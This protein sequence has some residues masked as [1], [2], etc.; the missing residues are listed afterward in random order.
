[1][2]DIKKIWATLKKTHM[3]KLIYYPNFEPRDIDWLKYA[4]IYVDQFSPIIPKSGKGTLSSDFTRIENETDLVKILE[5][6]WSQGDNAATK[7]LKEIEY[8][9]SHPDQFMDILGVVNINRTWKDPKNWLFELYEEK[10]NSTFKSECL[11]KGLGVE[12]Q[13]GILTSK[14]LAQLYMTFLAEEIAFDNVANPITDSKKYDQLSNYLRAKSPQKENLLNSAKTTV[15][16]S[17][18]KD[19]RHVDLKKFIEFRKDS[20]IKELRNSF[21]QSLSKFYESIED[22]FNPR[23]YVT[24]IQSSN[25]EL[26]KEIGLF[27]GGAISTTL[28]GMILISN[29]N[30]LEATKQ[31][32]EGTILTILGVTAIN[33]SWA[34]GREKRHARKFLSK[35][36]QI[37]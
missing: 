36:N 32:I 23:E 26:T 14:E 34:D 20:G 6:K 9:E 18:P 37:E 35:I 13:R 31:I 17:L 11:R 24:N 3:D 27:F 8:I 15:N 30:N 21:N 4:L 7:A 33:K 28:G 2:R 5:P 25:S 10:F 12:S 1:M 19:I 22:D 16:I 29:P